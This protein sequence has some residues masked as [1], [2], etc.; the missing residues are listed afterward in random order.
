MPGIAEGEPP[1]GPQV[2]L[3]VSLP[4]A[5]QGLS[6]LP[7][8]MAIKGPEMEKMGGRMGWAASRA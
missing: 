5:W 7:E 3:P 4:P 6:A 1:S 8:A 2:T